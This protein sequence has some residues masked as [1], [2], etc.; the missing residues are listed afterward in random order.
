MS[1]ARDHHGGEMGAD[2]GSLDYSMVVEGVF[3]DTLSRQIDEDVRMR[4]TG[5]GEDALN[6]SEVPGDSPRCILMNGKGEY[7]KPKII[8]TI[9]KQW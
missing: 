9:F 2:G 3:R 4:R 1:H 6:T 5:W 7:F 8:Q